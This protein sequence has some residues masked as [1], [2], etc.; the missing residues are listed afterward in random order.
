VSVRDTGVGIDP[1]DLP[2]IFERFYRATG[3]RQQ[4]GTGLG[5]SIA[6]WLAEQH[7]GRISV[8]SR[9]GRGSRFT[10]WLPVLE[11]EPAVVDSGA[12]AEPAAEPRPLRE[13]ASGVR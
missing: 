10:V 1:A 2:H 13:Q 7:G 6:R 4:G 8:E 9:Q 3:V 11:G 12:P 5:L